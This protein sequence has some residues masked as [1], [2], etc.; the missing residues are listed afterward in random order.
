VTSLDVQSEEKGELCEIYLLDESN[1]M[2]R[3]G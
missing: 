3:R 2:D 1:K